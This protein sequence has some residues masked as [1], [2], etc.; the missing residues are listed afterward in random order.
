MIILYLALALFGLVFA[1]VPTLVVC[2]LLLVAWAVMST[3]RRDD[4]RP[5]Q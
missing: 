1:P 4:R 3:A 2:A 5:R